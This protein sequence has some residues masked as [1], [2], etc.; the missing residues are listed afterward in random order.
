MRV[1]VTGAFGF[2]GTAVTRQLTLAGHQV[3]A[4]TGR[5]G[6][7]PG[8]VPAGVG[9]VHGDIRD[10]AAMKSALQ[11]VEGVCHLAALTRV[12]ES[13]E[14]PEE[15]FDV[16]L[17]GTGTLLAAVRAQGEQVGRPLC[18]V[19]ASTGAVYGAAG[20]QPIN[21]DAPPAPAS[22]YG[23]SKLAADQAALAAAGPGGPGVVVLRAFNVAGASGGRGDDDLTRIIPKA[24]AVARGT[25]PVLQINGDGGAVRD[26]VHVE[27]LARAYVS[28]LTHAGRGRG[29]VFNVGATRA[30]VADIV[31][32]VEQVT[33]RTVNVRHLPPGLEP[34]LLVADSSRIKAE[35][36][37]QPEC[38]AL[39]EIVSSAWQAA[40]S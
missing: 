15:Y 18:F 11:G 23:E 28:A 34:Q 39:A 24:L 21:E 14:R 1:L 4:L 19:Q 26:F 30:S 5:A 32:T 36:G 29:A 31:R 38:S 9:V 40:R 10:A 27:D 22:P 20:R 33:G 35:L 17:V 37:W 12:R 8:P 6:N 25:E 16:N 2:V 3:V 7:A 13:F